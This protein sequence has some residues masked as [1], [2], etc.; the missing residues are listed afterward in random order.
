MYNI[1]SMYIPSK[2]VVAK[3]TLDKLLIHIFETENSLLPFSSFFFHFFFSYQFFIY[4]DEMDES[5]L[6]LMRYSIKYA[7]IKIRG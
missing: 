1:Y 3:S 7:Y 5:Y 6:H 2:F 4:Q